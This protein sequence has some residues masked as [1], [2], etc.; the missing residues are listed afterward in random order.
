MWLFGRFVQIL[1]SV[2]KGARP[3]RAH[4]ALNPDILSDRSQV[5]PDGYSRRKHRLAIT[6]SPPR[7]W[8]SLRD[9]WDGPK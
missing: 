2:S 3:D 9:C 4:Q 6:A 8:A 7:L 5:L 1:R